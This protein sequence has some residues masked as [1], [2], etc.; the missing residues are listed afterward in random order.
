MR[1]RIGGSGR[2]EENGPDD[3]DELLPFRPPPLE[4]AFP[5]GGDS[6]DASA[7]AAASAGSIFPGSLQETGCFESVQGGIEGAFLHAEETVTGLLHPFENLETVSGP[8]FEE[9]EDHGVEVS[10]EFVA[11]NF[12]HDD[13]FSQTE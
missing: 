6:V 4:L 11:M 9:G 5:L 7:S 12:C 13:I 10:A 2:G 3:F 8:P 1:S